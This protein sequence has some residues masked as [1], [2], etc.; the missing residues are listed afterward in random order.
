[1]N[2]GGYIKDGKLVELRMVNY[3]DAGEFIPEKNEAVIALEDGDEGKS[4][5]EITEPRR[6]KIGDGIHSYKDLPYGEGKIPPNIVCPRAFLDDE[7]EEIFS[8]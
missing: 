4:Q 6:Y 2:I 8:K 7:M 1:M 3:N 5:F